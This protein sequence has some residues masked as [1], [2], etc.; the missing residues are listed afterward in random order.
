M[1]QYY[2]VI[3][4]HGPNPVHVFLTRPTGYSTPVRLTPL[5]PSARVASLAV[6]PAVARATADPTWYAEFRSAEA[7][8]QAGFRPLG[9]YRVCE[10]WDE[11]ADPWAAE[12]TAAGTLGAEETDAADGFPI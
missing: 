2:L 1:L 3:D 10:T 4:T 12:P 11:Y 6:R 7:A 9:A 5:D 8:V